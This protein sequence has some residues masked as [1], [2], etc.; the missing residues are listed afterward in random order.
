MWLCDGDSQGQRGG[1]VRGPEGEAPLA[2][3]VVLTSSLLQ[4]TALAD[5]T[6]LRGL[7]RV[8]RGHAEPASPV[9]LD[10]YPSEE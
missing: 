8:E 3:G 9:I 2:A 1:R 7:G 6:T 4:L 10:R 5:G